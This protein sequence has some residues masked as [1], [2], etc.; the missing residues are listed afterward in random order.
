MKPRLLGVVLCGGR[1]SRMGRDKASLVHPDGGTFLDHATNRLMTICDQ[2]CI[3]GDA[4]EQDDIA[5][6]A[7]PTPFRGPATGVAVAL[8]RAVRDNAAACLVTP[9]DMPFLTTSDLVTLTSVWSSSPDSLVCGVSASDKQIQP[10][11]A[12]YPSRCYT[13]ILRLSQSHQRSLRRWCASQNYVTV[14]LP[15]SACR[16]VN[17]PED[18]TS[19]PEISI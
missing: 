7:D 10:L 17:T 11:V 18:L 3:A 19:G 15:G 8:A 5:I 6:L 16:N 9:V 2:V 14:T 4:I 12:I 13:D 1:S